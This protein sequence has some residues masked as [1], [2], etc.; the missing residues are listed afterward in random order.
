MSEFPNLKT[1]FRSSHSLCAIP[2][3]ISQSLPSIPIPNIFLG[4]SRV[5]FGRFALKTR[6]RAEIS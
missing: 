3:L 4:R 2:R 6:W 5:K 1:N